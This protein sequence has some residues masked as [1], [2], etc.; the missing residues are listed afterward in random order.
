MAGNSGAGHTHKSLADTLGALGPGGT[1][2]I[3]FN[4]YVRLFGA[5]PTGEQLE[6]QREAD[7]FAALHGCEHRVDHAAKR[8]WFTKKK[9]A[10]TQ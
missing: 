1:A 6:S 10:A 7:R 8:V 3:G 4:D 5:Q 9:L 2:A